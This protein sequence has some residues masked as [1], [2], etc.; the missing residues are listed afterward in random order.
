MT[1]TIRPYETGYV[2]VI[3]AK[4][5]YVTYKDSSKIGTS[6]ESNEE[7]IKMLASIKKGNEH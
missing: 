3:S 4:G 1:S 7:S 2:Q 6:I 5:V